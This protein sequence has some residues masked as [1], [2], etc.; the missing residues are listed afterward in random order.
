MKSIS[1]VSEN[2]VYYFFNEPRPDEYEKILEKL[3][4]I[5]NYVAGGDYWRKASS[6]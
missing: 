4:A 1:M 6:Q 5:E 3:A 2:P